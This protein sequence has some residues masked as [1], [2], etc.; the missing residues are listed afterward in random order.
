MRNVLTITHNILTQDLRRVIQPTSIHRS[1]ACK[2]NNGNHIPI[3]R[4]LGKTTFIKARFEKVNVYHKTSNLFLVHNTSAHF[5]KDLIIRL[6]GGRMEL[7]ATPKDHSLIK[8]LLTRYLSH[9]YILFPHSLYHFPGRRQ[10]LS[11][12]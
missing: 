11:L 3:T 4:K 8:S 12:T 7:Q 9:L 5:D 10:H 1:Q 6:E 2:G